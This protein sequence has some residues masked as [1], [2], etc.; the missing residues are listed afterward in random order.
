MLDTSKVTADKCTVKSDESGA[1]SGSD[2]EW[3]TTTVLTVEV[4]ANKLDH[5]VK[6]I[7][8]TENC[9]D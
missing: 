9:S 6:A 1:F 8:A 2:C 7:C 4:E 3:A 5:H